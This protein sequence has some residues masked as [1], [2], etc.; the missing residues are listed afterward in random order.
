MRE[1][2][3]TSISH[4]Y[5]RRKKINTWRVPCT[6]CCTQYRFNLSSAQLLEYASAASTLAWASSAV[7]RAVHHLLRKWTFAVDGDVPRP[8]LLSKGG[9]D[10]EL[11]SQ[12]TL[13]VRAVTPVQEKAHQPVVVFLSQDTT[14]SLMDQHPRIESCFEDSPADLSVVVRR[15]VM[16][17]LPTSL[18]TSFQ[19]PGCSSSE[20]GTISTASAA[21]K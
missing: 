14:F 1:H 5:P 7:W 3:Q 12:P 6:T 2:I 16:R 19:P 10:F 9:F 13:C 15:L 11:S 20:L 21:G 8:V 17:C 4:P 18:L